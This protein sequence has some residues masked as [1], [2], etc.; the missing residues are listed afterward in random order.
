LSNRLLGR[1]IKAHKDIVREGHSLRDVPFQDVVYYAC[2][3]ADVTLQLTGILQQEL[4]RRNVE[5]Q[6]RNITLPIV[7]K[8]GDWECAGIPIDLDR[9]WRRRDMAADQVSAAKEAV[10]TRVESCFN[11]DSYQEVTAVLTM[12]KV[13]ASIIGFRRVNAKLLEELA[14]SHELPRLLV[15][16][17]RAQKRLRNIKL[18]IES[19]QNGRV[20]PAFSQTSTDHCRVSSV[21]PRLL[22]L[23]MVDDLCSCLPKGLRVFCPDARRALRVLAVEA[24]DDVLLGDLRTA[25]RSGCFPKVTPLSDGQHFQ[26]LLSFI[27][28]VSDYQLCRMF[29]LDR[30]AVESIRH[31]FQI[32]YSQTFFWLGK[33]RETTAKNGFASARGRRRHFDGLRSSD[34][35]KRNSALHSAVKW[36]VGW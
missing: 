19:I 35:E 9:L 28:G 26:L 7:K 29:L 3:H 13:L 27:T 12:D 20:H 22:D 10:V 32:R 14:I 6:Y 17:H 30:N 36:V 23:D 18:V 33:F 25:S 2:E 16:Y 34:L 15:R 4:A 8:L 1:A 21:K 5:D 31:D 11:L 24:A